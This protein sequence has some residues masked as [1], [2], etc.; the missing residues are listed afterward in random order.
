MCKCTCTPVYLIVLGI[1]DIQNISVSSLIPG[2]VRVTG[3]FIQGSAATGILVA[4]LTTSEILYLHIIKRNSSRLH[5][6]VLLQ[7]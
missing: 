7:L 1:H 3:D 4:V 2:Q 6:E 5:I